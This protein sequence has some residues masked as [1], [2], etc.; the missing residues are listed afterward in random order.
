VK[1]IAVFIFVL[2]TV[3]GCKSVD[4]VE[5]ELLV[6]GMKNPANTVGWYKQVLDLQERH[7]LDSCS[8]KEYTYRGNSV[9]VMNNGA[10]VLRYHFL[11]QLPQIY[12][13]EGV[14]IGDTWS[15]NLF[16]EFYKEAKFV[17]NIWKKN[18]S[19]P[20]LATDACGSKDP[21]KDF[22]FLSKAVDFFSVNAWKAAV[23]EYEY[24]GS[25][26]FVGMYTY[27]PNSKVSSFIVIDC[28]GVRLSEGANWNQ[29]DFREKA[30]NLGVLYQKL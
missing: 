6:C 11:L 12:N 10:A 29:K 9:Y 14:D 24:Q 27:T 30:K 20:S 5:P 4:N 16:T 8:I 22:S 1:K 13:C 7:N 2:V 15:E 18:I 23:Y 17:K 21:I 19:K 28:Q 25:I 26:V 3:I